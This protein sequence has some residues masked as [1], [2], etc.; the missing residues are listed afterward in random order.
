M[1][2][3]VFNPLA[4]RAEVEKTER[5]WWGRPWRV[6]GR[7]PRGLHTRDSCQ[8]IKYPFRVSETNAAV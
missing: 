1:P 2:F 8:A 7:G 6:V 3:N 5:G 4:K